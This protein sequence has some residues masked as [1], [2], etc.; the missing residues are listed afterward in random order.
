[1]EARAKLARGQGLWS[2]IW[3]L[4]YINSSKWPLPEIDIVEALGR[5]D[6][7]WYHIASHAY[8]LEGAQSEKHWS[9]AVTGEFNVYDEFN[10]FFVRLTEKAIYAGINGQ[11]LV[12]FPMPEEYKDL[13]WHWLLNLAGGGNWAG[14][15]DKSILPATMQVEYLKFYQTAE[16]DDGPVIEQESGENNNVSAEPPMVEAEPREPVKSMEEVTEDDDDD[17]PTLR[18]GGKDASGYE[19]GFTHDIMTGKLRWANH[20]K[21]KGG[22]K[23]FRNGVYVTTVE[24]PEYVTFQRGF[25]SVE[26]TT[27]DGRRLMRSSMFRIRRD[28]TPPA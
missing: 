20:S 3:L 5:E 11:L 25:Y 16:E 17:A 7:H 26:P 24:E 22:Y 10:T 15:V 12:S 21:A 18:T 14:K 4:A 9:E 1:M 2:A 6:A 28:I 13:K 27:A 8:H 19:V 23:V